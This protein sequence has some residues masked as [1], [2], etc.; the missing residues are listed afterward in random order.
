MKELTKQKTENEPEVKEAFFH[1]LNYFDEAKMSKVVSTCSRHKLPYS[2]SWGLTV[3]LFVTR[4]QISALN[5][6]QH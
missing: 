6:W 3:A 2:L 4:Y 5:Q 1:P